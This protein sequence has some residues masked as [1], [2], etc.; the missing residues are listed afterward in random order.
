MTGEPLQ[1]FV[2]TRHVAAS[3]TQL[4]FRGEQLAQEG[5]VLGHRPLPPATP[6]SE[7]LDRHARPL[8][9]RRKSG[10]SGRPK[11]LAQE[12]L[13]GLPTVRSSCQLRVRLHPPLADQV[14]LATHRPAVAAEPLGDL[15]TGIAFHSHQRDLAECVVAQTGH[16]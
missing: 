13:P 8:R 16:K 7:A 14:E 1:V 4:Q 11:S 3:P 15:V 2:R 6:R 9:R 12:M 5:G 10:R